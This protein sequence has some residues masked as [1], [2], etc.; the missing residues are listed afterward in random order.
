MS[1]FRRAL[2]AAAL[3]VAAGGAMFTSA[4]GAAPAYAAIPAPPTAPTVPAGGHAIE[5]TAQLAT[6][7]A[8]GIGPQVVAPCAVPA[9]A[10]PSQS[11][12][13]DC[14]PQQIIC[15][16]TVSTPVLNEFRSIVASASAHCDHPVDALR[17]GE[18]LYKNN[19]GSI[20]DDYDPEP[21][22][23]DA[24]TAVLG[25]ACQPVPYDNF[26][27]AGIDWPAGYTDNKTGGTT[28]SLHD[29]ESFTPTA[30]ACA[31]PP[32]P[33]GGGSGGPVGGCAT[34]SPPSSAQPVADLPRL[35][36]C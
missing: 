30:S 21:N 29:I 7:R 20:S 4:A 32:P 28:G 14:L 5:L 26:G 31:P 1:R 13:A 3:A 17:L 23:T 10:S 18:S 6:Q 11:A 12:P 25:G 19:G 8:G 36:T 16:I 15:W 22:A 9:L 34:S 27:F 2:A 24:S 35:H 33:G